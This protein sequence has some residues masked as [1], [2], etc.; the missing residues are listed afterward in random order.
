MTLDESGLKKLA[1]APSLEKI[2]QHRPA[3]KLNH[4]AMLRLQAKQQQKASNESLKPFITSLT[5]K[6]DKGGIKITSKPASS[7]KPIHNKALSTNPTGKETTSTKST[8]T[9]PAQT[10]PENIAPP[11][12]LGYVPH[13]G[14]PHFTKYKLIFNYFYF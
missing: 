4:A 14:N 9:A 2:L 10:G 6:I 12:K 5:P 11:K 3:V 1:P 7:L 8:A 13:K